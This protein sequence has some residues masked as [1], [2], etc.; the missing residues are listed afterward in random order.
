MCVCVLQAL[1]P[2]GLSAAWLRQGRQ[3]D[4]RQDGH[5]WERTG[6][7]EGEALVEE[8]GLQE[9]ELDLMARGASLLRSV[10]VGV[11]EVG[12]VGGGQL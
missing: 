2:S 1:S 9:V 5:R 3:R 12:V 8:A 7:Q 11:G 6:L 10:R 4:R